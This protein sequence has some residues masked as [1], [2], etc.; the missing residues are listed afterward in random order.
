MGTHPIFESDFDCLTEYGLMLCLFRPRFYPFPRALA[1]STALGATTKNYYEILGVGP[2]ASRSE[3]KTAYY[4]LARKFHPDANPENPAAAKVFEQVSEA[5]SV[6]RDEAKRGEF[7][8][9]ANFSAATDLG[10]FEKDSRDK[11]DA[12]FDEYS[13]FGR[14][15]VADWMVGADFTFSQSDNIPKSAQVLTMKVSFQEAARGGSRR[16]RVRLRDT[17]PVC[18]GSGADL[19]APNAYV[20]TC[21]RCGGTG[22]EFIK[23]G[24]LST[25]ADCMKCRGSGS[26]ATQTCNFCIGRGWN[27]QKKSVTCAIP[28][29]VQDQEIVRLNVGEQQV[30]VKYQVMPDRIFSRDGND[31]LQN[32]HLPV[33][34]LLLGGG[35]KCFSLSENQFLRLTIPECTAP[36]SLLRIKG[37]GIRDTIS[38]TYGDMLIKVHLEAPRNLTDRQRRE[39][40]NFALDDDY[41]GSVHGATRTGQFAKRI[42]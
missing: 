41:D 31:V 32:L 4:K 26:F 10:E 14:H 1:T 18:E 28:E 13:T 7:D 36:D 33:S 19:S 11:Y 6:L 30:Y 42:E 39:M 3:I 38:N 9:D 29:G 17:C 34:K 22:K 35:V 12:I 37:Q 20:F 2:T 40:L 8:A 25:K 27:V 15:P 5:Y 16:I 21:P 23:A 24:P